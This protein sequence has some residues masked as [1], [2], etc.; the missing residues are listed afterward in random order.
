MSRV[1]SNVSAIDAC[2]AHSKSTLRA[3]RGGAGGGAAGGAGVRHHEQHIDNWLLMLHT[4][5]LHCV[6][7]AAG[8]AVERQEA[9][10]SGIMSNVEFA[11]LD[12]AEQTRKAIAEMGHTRLTEV[13]ARTIPPLLLGRDVLGAAKTGSGKTLVSHEA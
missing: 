3:D 11:G 1:M 4:S 2:V 8:Q 5:R 9:Q 13:Q 6:Q 10:V 7:T 12:V